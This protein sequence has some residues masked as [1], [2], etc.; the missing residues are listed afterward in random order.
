MWEDMHMQMTNRVV[1][2]NVEAISKIVGSQLLKALC[3]TP[4]V[5]HNLISIIASNILFG[6]GMSFVHHTVRLVQ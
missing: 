2:V 1:R 4:E 5:F 3:N 6:K